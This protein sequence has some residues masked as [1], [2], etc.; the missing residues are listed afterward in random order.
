MSFLRSK[1][2]REAFWVALVFLGIATLCHAQVVDASTLE[3]KG[4]AE[5]HLL[6]NELYAR[7]GHRFKTAYLTELFSLR[8][9]SATHNMPMS[10]DVQKSLAA[11]K[12]AETNAWLR[13][14]EAAREFPLNHLGPFVM[15]TG[16]LDGQ[17][18][19]EGCFKA[20]LT[21][22]RGPEVVCTHLA[23]AAEF[24]ISLI[25]ID[26]SYVGLPAMFIPHSL[27]LVDVEPTDGHK[28]LEI[29]GSDFQGPKT[30]L[31]GVRSKQAQIILR[32]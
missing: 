28:E 4:T 15:G 19:K 20:D 31:I 10:A 8:W 2:I 12:K 24:H 22:A 23:P 6:R 11:I 7:H 30:Y 29:T 5:L 27:K 9:T 25:G 1:L 21:P 26:G 3:G 14:R 18:G 16:P 13:A 32:Q 17:Q